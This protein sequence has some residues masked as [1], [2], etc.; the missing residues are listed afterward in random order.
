M[1]FGIARRADLSTLTLTGEFRGTLHYAAPEQI[2]AKGSG[3]DPRTDVYALGI[4]LYEGVTGRV[5]FMGETTEQVFHQILEAE[6][7]SPRCLNPSL[8]R[9][10][11]TIIA[12]A[13]EKEPVRRY[14]TMAELQ[15][16][17]RTPTSITWS[18]GRLKNEVA[19]AAF[20][21]M[22]INR[23]ARQRVIRDA[24]SMTRLSRPM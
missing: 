10:L 1:D 20:R 2:K 9:D 11:D 6:P 24:S 8:P 14:Q 16:V 17:K 7:L 23:P 5:P 4:T 18:A 13:M 15:I 19:S 12:K 22:N 21:D 3:I